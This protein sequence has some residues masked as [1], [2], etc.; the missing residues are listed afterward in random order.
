MGKHL[1]NI[2]PYKGKLFILVFLYTYKMDTA[3]IK[4]IIQEQV[5]E[6]NSILAKKIIQRDVPDLNKFIKHPN[7]LVILGLRRCGKSVLSW[8]IMGNKQYCYI[9]FDD[10]AL[11]G[12]TAKD[13]NSVIS[14]FHELY[15][16]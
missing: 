9:N 6:R 15:D 4:R 13:L 8:L 11:Y 2:C 5:K 14:A 16:N 1:I 12:M 7:I 3:E 10:E